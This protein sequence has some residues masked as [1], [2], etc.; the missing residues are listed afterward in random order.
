[1]G[2]C[3]LAARN[4]AP[5][6]LL[7]DL[8]I[9]TVIVLN[10]DHPQDCDRDAGCENLLHVQDPSSQCDEDAGF[11]ATRNVQCEGRSGNPPVPAK[12]P[13]VCAKVNSIKH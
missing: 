4:N 6:R 13:A 3:L 10:V 7:Y 11:V 9:A 5:E 8:A 2:Y 1:M 12:E